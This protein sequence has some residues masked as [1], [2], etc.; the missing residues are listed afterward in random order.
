[1]KFSPLNITGPQTRIEA[2][3]TLK[4]SDQAL[5]LVVGVDLTG[6]LNEKFNPFKPITDILN[7]LN[8]L[9]QFRI[10]GTLD[11]QTVRSLYDPRNLLPGGND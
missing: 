4:L 9:L 5:D 6:S 8:Y 11:D 7:P 2:N 1:L 3:G 10:T